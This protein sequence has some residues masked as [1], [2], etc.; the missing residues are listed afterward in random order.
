MSQEN[1]EAP[2]R[3]FDAFNRGD[4]DA[5]LACLDPGVEFRPLPLE[6]E[7]GGPY[8]GHDGVRTWLEG[9]FQVFPDFSG[10]SRRYETWETSGSRECAFGA[11]A[12]RATRSPR[13]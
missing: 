6:L 8:R 5:F 9:Q 3:V 12:W 2:Q 1:I 10:R 13:P 11:M 4:V 7:G